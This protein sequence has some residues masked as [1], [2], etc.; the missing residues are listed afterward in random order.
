M[1]RRN[2]EDWS[3]GGNAQAAQARE[4][5]FNATARLKARRD[6]AAREADRQAKVE[7]L[8]ALE[9]TSV[10][11]CE[12]LERGDTPS[13]RSVERAEA[14]R[15]LPILGAVANTERNL[16]IFRIWCEGNDYMT[17]GLRCDVTPA[18]ARLI[19]RRLVSRLRQLEEAKRRASK[20][21]R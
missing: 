20:Q 8:L 2:D 10:V 11:A 16:E 3:D 7:A 9:Q 18:W 5:V 1:E 6:A 15:A 4:E 17:V 13:R 21:D 12:V 14:A 19:C